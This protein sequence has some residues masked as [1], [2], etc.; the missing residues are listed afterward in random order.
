MNDWETEIGKLVRETY[1]REGYSDMLIMI[2]GIKNNQICTQV[3]YPGDTG[4]DFDLR[5]MTFA[6]LNH[7]FSEYNEILNSDEAQED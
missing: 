4:G 3:W 6:L 1:R 5:F 2:G 7:L